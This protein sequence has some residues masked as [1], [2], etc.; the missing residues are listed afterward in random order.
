MNINLYI[1]YFSNLFT[2]QLVPEEQK[3]TRNHIKLCK[4][5]EK[6]FFKTILKQK[7]K[8]YQTYTVYVEGDQLM[9]WKQTIWEGYQDYC[10]IIDE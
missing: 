10:V 3:P 2:F 5:I 1:F 9:H 4:T 6:K 8:V 7:F